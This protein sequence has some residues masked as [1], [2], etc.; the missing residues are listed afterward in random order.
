MRITLEKKSPF[1]GIKSQHAFS[2]IG[3]L[4]L[5]ILS[6]DC[7]VSPNRWI[8]RSL[9]SHLVRQIGNQVG[10]S[11]TILNI[12]AT[13]HPKMLLKNDWNWRLKLS[14]ETVGVIVWN[15]C[16]PKFHMPFCCVL[17]SVWI[18]PSELLVVLI[19]YL[20][21]QQRTHLL[22]QCGQLTIFSE[23]IKMVHRVLIL[24]L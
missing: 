13:T 24:T 3:W 2:G 20:K 22:P 4:G 19:Q 23:D 16:V 7:Q 12:L 15:F 8:K 14:N 5:F 17:G 21:K 9:S 18:H 11:I 6:L 10:I 1:H